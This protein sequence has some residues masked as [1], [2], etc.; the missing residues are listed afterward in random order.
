MIQFYLYFTNIIAVY[1]YQLLVPYM[2]TGKVSMSEGPM[3]MLSA[4]LSNSCYSGQIIK[5]YKQGRYSDIQVKSK[6]GKEIPAHR[7]T[8]NIS[9]IIWVC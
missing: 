1:H 4:G 5:H 9:F 8:T 3:L 7:Y 6:D 2:F